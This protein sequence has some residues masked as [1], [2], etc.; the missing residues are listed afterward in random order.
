M[1]AVTINR[2]EGVMT[3]PEFLALGFTCWH[4]VNWTTANTEAAAREFLKRRGVEAGEMY[5]V[6]FGWL[7]PVGVPAREPKRTPAELI[8][9]V[10]T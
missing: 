2:A 3:F 10:V 1:N 6:P 8:G 4:E 5:H 7:A 9:R